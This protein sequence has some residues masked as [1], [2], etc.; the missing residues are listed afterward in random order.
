M[1]MAALRGMIERDGA[2]KVQPLPWARLLAPLDCPCRS[3]PGIA[4][5]CRE[6][7]CGLHTMA[8]TAGGFGDVAGISMAC[9]RLEEADSIIINP[10][11]PFNV[12]A[13]LSGSSR[14]R[15]LERLRRVHPWA[16]EV[17]GITVES[18]KNYMTRH[19]TRPEIFVP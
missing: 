8:L 3:I 16:S 15:D 18:E 6:H 7:K 13:G 9:G 5:I 12:S 14:G 11:R 4:K 2:E 10:T 17:A 1:D 19:S